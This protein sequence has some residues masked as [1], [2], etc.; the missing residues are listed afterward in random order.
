MS[1][2][3]LRNR[4]ARTSAAC[5]FAACVA[6]LVPAMAIAADPVAVSISK[7]AF[8]PAEISIAAGTRV[9]WKN[10]DETPHTLASRD[11]TF[12]SKALDTD[13]TFEHT[14]TDAGDFS[15]FCT[16]HPFMTGVVHVHKQ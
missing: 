11:K 7:F 1:N 8:T 16:L 6:M 2:L 10:A 12:A 9:V 5:L 15:Y 3:F 13:D 14:F 4:L